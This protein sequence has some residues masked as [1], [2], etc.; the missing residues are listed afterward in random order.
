MTS[1]NDYEE[2]GAMAQTT[3]ARERERAWRRRFYDPWGLGEETKPF[4]LTS[5]F[6]VAV[7]T[8]VAILIGTSADNF[9]APRAWVLVSVV[10]AAYIISRGLAKAGS[11]HFDRDRD[12]GR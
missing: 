10:A 2:A 7:T 1:G 6:W 4:F 12:M 3:P 8:V 11:R 9:D 5:E